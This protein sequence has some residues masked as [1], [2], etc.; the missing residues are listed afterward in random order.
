MIEK[1]IRNLPCWNGPIKIEPLSGGNTNQNFK[2]SDSKDVY[3]V[4]YCEEIPLLGISR[5]NEQLC[6][7]LAFQAG[8][9]PELIHFQEEFQVTRFVDGRTF[10]D[11]MARQPDNLKRIAKALNQLHSFRDKIIGEPVYFSVFQAVNTYYS[12]ANRLGAG[13]PSDIKELMLKVTQL[14]N[15]ME[16]YHPTLCHNDMVAANVIGDEDRIWIVDWEYSGIGNPLFDLAGISANCSLTPEQESF[17]VSAYFGSDNEK[18]LKDVRILKIA[19][20]LREALWASIQTKL[21]DLDFDYLAYGEEY[22]GR[23]RKTV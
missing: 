19:S 16:P 17:F 11:E 8:L 14:A 22:Y 18:A 4:R 23:F 15:K 20:L 10:D 2:V 5:Q 6:S 13:L 1:G 9:A 7:T 3:V 12:T 21:S